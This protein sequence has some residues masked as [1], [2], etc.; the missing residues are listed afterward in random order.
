MKLPKI[1]LA[2]PTS[3]NKD[4]CLD[5]FLLQLSKFTYPDLNM[6]IIDNSHKERRKFLFDKFEKYNI[7]SKIIYMYYYQS[8]LT[9]R[10]LIKDCHNIIRDFALKTNCDYVYFLESDH[11]TAPNTIEHLL[12][13]KKQI[14]GLPYFIGSHFASMY[15][16]S[17]TELCGNMALE[18][19]LTGNNGFLYT[20]G[21]LKRTYQLGFGNILIHR[22]VLEKITFRVETEGKYNVES[23]FDDQFFYQDCKK[24]GIPVYVD[25][26]NMSYHWNVHWNRLIKK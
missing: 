20:D 4:Y 10:E 14:V 21:L 12:S 22:S 3:D 25:T 26:A 8:D 11:F 1:L 5:E 18:M 9:F 24:L 15:I 17:E 6:L 19:A 23:Y 13:L 2:F 7:Q 16:C